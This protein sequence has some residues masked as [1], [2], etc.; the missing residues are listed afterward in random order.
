[1]LQRTP[2]C[3]Q[4]AMLTHC[5]CLR[6]PPQRPHS[7]SR[8]RKSPDPTPVHT[9]KAVPQPSTR[10]H[11][12]HHP[13]FAPPRPHP[14][15]PRR[16]PHAKSAP[17]VA[18]PRHRPRPRPAPQHLAL[19]AGQHRHADRRARRPGAQGARPGVRAPRQERPAAARAG[20]PGRARDRAQHGREERRAPE[21]GEQGPRRAVDGAHGGRGERDELA[22]RKGWR[23]RWRW[24][25]VR[26]GRRLCMRGTG[27]V[28]AAGVRR[29]PLVGLL[30]YDTPVSCLDG[31][32]GSRCGK[33][34]CIKPRYPVFL[35]GHQS[36]CHSSSRGAMRMYRHWPGT[37]A[38]LRHVR[39]ISFSNAATTTLV[40]D[41]HRT[42]PQYQSS[43]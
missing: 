24:R 43:A 29:F 17:G 26:P 19:A 14:R 21:G 16:N 9:N 6:L 3:I 32:C 35:E 22:E 25:C 11:Y 33:I 40:G 18:A 13:S 8:S 2:P 37:P 4:L 27:L 39:A 31:H 28:G 1:M 42:C 38:F 7:N 23:W 12:H 36:Y 20:R 15:R 34:R 10:R 30:L 5:F 41:F